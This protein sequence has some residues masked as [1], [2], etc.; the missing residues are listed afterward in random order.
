M[1][2]KERAFS[3]L[4]APWRIGIDVGGPFTD[5]APTDSAA[6]SLTI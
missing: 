5:L 1:D 6:V 2:S 3:A 4:Q